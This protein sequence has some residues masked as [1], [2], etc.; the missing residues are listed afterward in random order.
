MKRI[1]S[2]FIIAIILCT[3][4]FCAFA[5]DN[6]AAVSIVETASN[7]YTVYLGFI[8]NAKEVCGGGMNLVYN[9]DKLKLVDYSVDSERC[10]MLI[11]PDYQNKG[12]T[13]R[14]VFAS[15]NALSNGENLATIKFSSSGDKATS[16]DFSVSEYRLYDVNSSLRAN[17]K[18]A[19]PAI[20]FNALSD[21][22]GVNTSVVADGKNTDSARESTD[23]PSND[24]Y[25][26]PESIAEDVNNV[27]PDKTTNGTVAVN[28]ASSVK[29]SSKSRKALIISLI[30]SL[31]LVIIAAVIILIM[32]KKRKR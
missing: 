2:V 26:S 3:L 22:S 7:E 8:D 29:R 31:A 1:V 21:K 27:L 11:N 16:S 23:Y 28:S 20:S 15:A 6:T 32:R 13:V 19:S 18:S 14:F 25:F 30:V 24:A 4:P 9:S 17:D 12:N 10:M 5:A